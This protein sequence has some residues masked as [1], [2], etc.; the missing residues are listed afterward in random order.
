MKQ[1]KYA[2][3]LLFMITADDPRTQFEVAEIWPN[4][5]VVFDR[6]LLANNEQDWPATWV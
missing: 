1:A 2:R 3:F 5:G 6:R 4:F